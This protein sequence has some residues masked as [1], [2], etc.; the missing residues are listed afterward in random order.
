M[1]DFSMSFSNIFM[2]SVTTKKSIKE[3]RMDIDDKVLMGNDG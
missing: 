3:V 1:P 2:C